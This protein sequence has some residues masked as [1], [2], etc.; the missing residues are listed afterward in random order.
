MQK[1]KTL[2]FG[3]KTWNYGRKTIICFRNSLLKKSSI[4]NFSDAMNH[5]LAAPG[6]MI[7]YLY[8]IMCTK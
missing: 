1:R 8:I 2:F 4:V 6:M 3:V 7:L 5:R